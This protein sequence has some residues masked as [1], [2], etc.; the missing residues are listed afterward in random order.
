[1]MDKR[2]THLVQCCIVQVLGLECRIINHAVARVTFPD[3]ML[4]N[5]LHGVHSSLSAILF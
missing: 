3:A 5:E 4:L 1:V 2:L